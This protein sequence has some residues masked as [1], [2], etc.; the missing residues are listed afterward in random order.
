ML[1]RSLASAPFRRPSPGVTVLPG[2][3]LPELINND[4]S[5]LEDSFVVPDAAL[6]H[7]P[8][9]QRAP[10]VPAKFSTEFGDSFSENGA[11]ACG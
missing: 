3:R 4:K 1:E 2:R 7:V 5:L 11:R 8:A 10:V 6:A 9:G